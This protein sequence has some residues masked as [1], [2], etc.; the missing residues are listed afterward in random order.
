MGKT[1]KNFKIFSKFQLREAKCDMKEGFI[2][3]SKEI[4]PPG[5]VVVVYE[6]I[7]SLAKKVIPDPL[8]AKSWF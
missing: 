3:K 4:T 1:F 5:T 8:K 7:K 2:R 6:Y